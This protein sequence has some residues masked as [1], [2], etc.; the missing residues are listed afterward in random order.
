MINKMII[1][2]S[3]NQLTGLLDGYGL[4]QRQ[5]QM[6]TFFLKEPYL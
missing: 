3:S 4:V 2:N 6:K 5:R 1:R